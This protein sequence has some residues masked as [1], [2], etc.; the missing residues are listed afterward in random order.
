MC[1]FRVGFIVILVCKLV[2]KINGF[3]EHDID[4]RLVTFF[5]CPGRI[6]CVSALVALGLRHCACAKVDFHIEGDVEAVDLRRRILRDVNRLSVEHHTFSAHRIED[7]H[8]LSVRQCRQVVAFLDGSRGK[9]ILLRKQIRD[10]SRLGQILE[11]VEPEVLQEGLRRAIQQRASDGIV[12]PDDRD[13]IAIEQ[14]LE[15]VVGIHAA[16]R[17]DR[18]LRDRLPETD[19]RQRLER[20]LRQAPLRTLGEHATDIAADRSRRLERESSGDLCD[21]ERPP[22]ARILCIEC[23]DLRLQPVDRERLAARNRRSAR[24]GSF[25]RF[26][27]G[28]ALGVDRRGFG[29]DGGLLLP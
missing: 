19:D 17:L 26:H 8:T 14:A 21:A 27:R 18:R 28:I 24:R 9:F 16:N 7:A 13:Q 22:P 1:V 5:L 4:C 3:L 6:R 10:L 12:A 29:I 15:H 23:G 20:A 25:P 11:T 2:F